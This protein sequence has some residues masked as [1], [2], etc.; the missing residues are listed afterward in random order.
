VWLSRINPRSA[1]LISVDDDDDDDNQPGAINA[2]EPLRIVL[3]CLSSCDPLVAEAACTFIVRVCQQENAASERAFQ[4]EAVS[5]IKECMRAHQKSAQVVGHCF[6]ALWVLA[7]NPSNNDQIG[8]ISFLLA[9]IN[10]H[11]TSIKAVMHPAIL[12]LH[13]ILRSPLNLE[14]FGERG[15]SLLIEV[16]QT[17]MNDPILTKHTMHALALACTN[18]DIMRVLVECTNI[19]PIIQGIGNGKRKH[20]Q[21]GI[22]KAL[23]LARIDEVRVACARPLVEEIR[24]LHLQRAVVI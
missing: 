19:R 7:D 22:Q 21:S 24:N 3:A 23:I 10:V 6:R 5:Q 17:H 20:N 1:K 14:S 9:C 8:D 2:N 12:S 18:A 16:L 11:K 13:N 4:L 15:L